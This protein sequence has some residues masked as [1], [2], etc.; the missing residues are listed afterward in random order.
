MELTELTYL[1][2][3]IVKDELIAITKQNNNTITLNF[4]NNSYLITL[5]KKQCI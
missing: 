3:T 2:Y 5:T 1:I 4:N